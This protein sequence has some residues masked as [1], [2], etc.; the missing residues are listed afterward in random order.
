[1]MDPLTTIAVTVS[2]SAFVLDVLL[3]YRQFH[4]APW[5]QESPEADPE[6]AKAE[7]E[8]SSQTIDIQPNQ[9]QSL[10]ES[11]PVN[12]SNVVTY[13]TSCAE[14]EKS[15]QDE[16]QR[17]NSPAPD[18]IWP[19]P[20]APK[21]FWLFGWERSQ[22][23]LSPSERPPIFSKWYH[24]LK[25]LWPVQIMDE[26]LVLRPNPNQREVH[27]Q[28]TLSGMLCGGTVTM[29]LALGLVVSSIDGSGGLEKW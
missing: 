26:I 2:A 3:C 1:M 11:S 23:F 24:Y 20:D 29:K 25:I 22:R 13:E 5:K 15:A 16:I 10:N 12:P 21:W 27:P 9:N 19:P 7:R 18:P 4:V 8:P 6:A 14:E 28:A 17:L